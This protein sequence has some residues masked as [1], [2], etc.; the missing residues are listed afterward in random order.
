[1][2]VTSGTADSTAFAD[3]GVDI[4][5]AEVRID[6]GKAKRD[7]IRALLAMPRDADAWREARRP[8][9]VASKGRRR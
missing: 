4:A 9:V 8:V 1:V 3:A 7:H 6:M 5:E 2:T